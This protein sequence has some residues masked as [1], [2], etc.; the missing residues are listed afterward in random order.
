M[1]DELLDLIS[2]ILKNFATRGR[3]VE[4]GFKSHFGNFVFE[5]KLLVLTK[6]NNF[7]KAKERRT[8]E[9]M[10]DKPRRSPDL[11]RRDQLRKPSSF[12]RASGSIS[13]GRS[14][15]RRPAEAPDVPLPARKTISRLLLD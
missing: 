5:K 11:L 6:N 10:P 3:K 13:P 15:S 12:N 4:K 14:S 2:N 1:M 8:N 9:M 7:R